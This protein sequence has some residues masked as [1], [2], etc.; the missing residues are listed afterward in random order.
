LI[1]NRAPDPKIEEIEEIR[2]F[3]FLKMDVLSEGMAASLY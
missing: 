3:V 2:N 1:P